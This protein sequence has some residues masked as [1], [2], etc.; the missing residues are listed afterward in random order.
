MVNL[1]YAIY[2]IVRNIQPKPNNYEKGNRSATDI[3]EFWID[4]QSQRPKWLGVN[5]TNGHSKGR[6]SILCD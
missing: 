5:E 4:S 1:L 6:T 2:V 3:N